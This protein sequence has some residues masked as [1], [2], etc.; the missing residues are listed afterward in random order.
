P[1]GA[2]RYGAHAVAIRLWPDSLDDGL[3]EITVIVTNGSWNT[4]ALDAHNIGLYLNEDR[5]AVLGRSSMLARINDSIDEPS[6]RASVAT[7]SL[8]ERQTTP[9]SSTPD[10]GME[11]SRLGSEVGAM[12]VDPALAAAARR[13]NT[14]RRQTPGQARAG[15]LE[16]R[17][18]TINDWY[19][20]T[21]EIYP[22]DTRTGGIS[23]AVPDGDADLELHVSIGDEDYVFPIRYRTHQ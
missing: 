8:A 1:Y 20:E 5:L 13:A 6:P 23:I 15:N 14:N 22:G 17:R 10:G 19:L 7:D 9:R 2:V 3:A 21:I 12:A 11:G 4:I 18:A 16:E